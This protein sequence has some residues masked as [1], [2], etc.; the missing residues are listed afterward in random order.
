MRKRENEEREEGHLNGEPMKQFESTHGNL[1]YELS[2]N[3]YILSG[4]QFIWNYSIWN[5]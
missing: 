1:I 4:K 2:K 3:T 5:G